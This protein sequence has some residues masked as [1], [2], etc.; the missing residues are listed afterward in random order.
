[1]DSSQR[2]KFPSRFT[3]SATADTHTHT[4]TEIQGEGNAESNVVVTSDISI[5]QEEKVDEK[6]FKES[7][8][9]IE[10]SNHAIF[11]KCMNLFP[12]SSAII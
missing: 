1:M 10:I 2:K 6:V 12:I 7:S 9:V 8:P 5:E 11:K 3:G 4:D